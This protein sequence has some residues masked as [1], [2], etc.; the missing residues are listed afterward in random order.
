MHFQKCSNFSMNFFDI[1]YYYKKIVHP[2]GR[3]EGAS[4]GEGRG[5]KRTFPPEIPIL[6]K[7]KGFLLTH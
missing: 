4:R 1:K 2:K 6:K 5:D 7:I 3:R